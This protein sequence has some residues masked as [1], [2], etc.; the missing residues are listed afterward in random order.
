MHVEKPVANYPTT[1][2]SLV[3]KE[4][5]IKEDISSEKFPKFIDI[6]EDFNSDYEEI[7]EVNAGN[8]KYVYTNVETATSLEN[9]DQARLEGDSE[10]IN[11]I[12]NQVYDDPPLQIYEGPDTVGAQTSQDHIKIAGG[13]PSIGT[14][15]KVVRTPDEHNVVIQ[16]DKD[17]L[18]DRS[19]FPHKVEE[20]LPSHPRKAPNWKK[21]MDEMMSDREDHFGIYKVQDLK[22]RKNSPVSLLYGSLYSFW[23]N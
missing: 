22:S 15:H 13:H 3:A 14:V 2:E 20:I 8:H 7:H 9:L 18:D 4:V 19:N 10:V 6:A 23:G 1:T 12:Y 16:L 5:S 11:D 21:W 17:Q